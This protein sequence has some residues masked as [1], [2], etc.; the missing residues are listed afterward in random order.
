MVMADIEQEKAAREARARQLAPTT[1]PAEAD[2]E[3][4]AAARKEAVAR[5]KAAVPPADIE[6]EAAAREAIAVK[7]VADIE[8]EAAARIEAIE[9]AK[10]EIAQITTARKVRERDI[11][12]KLIESGD[13][14]TGSVFVP[15]PKGR[16][17]FIT[18]EEARKVRQS[19][20]VA[21]Q[22]L[23][24]QGFD[25]FK[26][27]LERGFITI[28]DMRMKVAVWNKIPG[29]YQSIA[30]QQNDFAAMTK[31][32]DRD[33]KAIEKEIEEFKR[34]HVVIRG[35]AMPN[36]EWK[37]LPENLKAIARRSGFDVMLETIG[38]GISQQD[39][40]IGVMSKFKTEDGF[41]LLT[42]RRKGITPETMTMAGFHEDDIKWADDALKA[43]KKTNI[44]LPGEVNWRDVRT[45]KTITDEAFRK[46]VAAKDSERD[47]F[48]R[49]APEVRRMVVQGV[50]TLF[51]S[52]TRQALP[53]VTKEDISGLE[54]AVGSAQLAMWAIP[55][56]PKGI[57]GVASTGASGIL[58]L[59]LGRQWGQ[60]S[61]GQRALATAGVVLVALPALAAVAK[62]AIPIAVRV[63]IKLA[64]KKPAEV[65]VWRGIAINGKPIIGISQSKLAIGKIGV[66]LPK[67]SEIQSGFTPATRIETSL[68]ATRKALRN[69]GAS[70][71]DI[72][73]VEATLDTRGMFAGKKSPYLDKTIEADPI[74]SLSK[75]GVAEVFK[76]SIAK[77]K[78]VE[79]VYG[80]YTIKA[81]LD[82]KLRLWRQLGDIDIQ[83]TMGAKET[84]AF[85]KQIANAL[86][87]IEGAKNVRISK[88]SP[89]LIQT[90]DATGW[91][92]AV[93]IHSREISSALREAQ[94]TRVGTTGEFSF[95][96]TVNEPAVSINYP[97]VGKVK[98]MRLSE[99]GKRKAD[100][101]LRFQKTKIAPE[102]HRVKDIADYYVILRTFKGQK[103]ADDW[104]RTF[105]Q[106]PGKLLKLAQKS[107]PK[108]TAWELSPSQLAKIG[109]G[110]PKVSVII[111]SSMVG[112]LS[113]GLRASIAASSPVSPALSARVIP[114]SPSPAPGSPSR[115]V[116][117]SSAVPSAVSKI[118]TK[119]DI[120][121]SIKVSP[122]LIRRPS[123]SPAPSK[124]VSAKPSAAPSVAPSPAP[125]PTP[126][127]AIALVAG[128]GHEPYQEINGVLLIGI[129]GRDDFSAGGSKAK[130]LEKVLAG[131]K[132]RYIFLMTHYPG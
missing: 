107:P 27:Q 106:D 18:A 54:Y 119:R 109:K 12:K 48:T 127:R 124:A 86:K 32:I 46:R 100:A 26:R 111:P 3:Q 79:R 29:K 82:P 25:A 89:T 52:P 115:S 36:K 14:P 97:G 1:A 28:G 30:I 47:H 131:S 77:G 129:Q 51:F 40:A 76:Q 95:G 69:M 64:G 67:F 108:L 75:D 53:E 24:S 116:S 31:A 68:L 92:H 117:V 105:G 80:S 83:T 23:K 78:Q 103:I 70:E 33:N 37:A 60:L 57:I 122:S 99:S 17:T 16:F 55:F 39:Q 45:G 8:Q 34:T 72:R 35:Q 13:I 59:N 6:Q 61:G 56:M 98:I 9:R 126:A 41:D 81:Q 121:A 62:T 50:S 96:M 71:V 123:T 112:K 4:E 85:T 20:P 90:R 49:V 118:T 66:K 120:S 2:I 110:Q 125:S 11:F 93:D 58:G 130:W 104:A 10:P 7:V 43:S 44:A 91:H 65:T 38:A 21:F 84:A 15:D 132:A 63:P 74:K 87:K 19:D 114:S 128:K 88:R 5:R 101:I 22:I 73:R 94:K 102:P 42:A 113:P